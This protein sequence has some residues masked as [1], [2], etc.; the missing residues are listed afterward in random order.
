MIVSGHN[1]SCW[2]TNVP[3]HK[4][5]WAQLCLGTN[6][7][8]HK[9]VWAQTCLRTIISG[10][11]HVWAQS[12]LGT[13]VSGHNHVWAQSCL[14][15]NVCG[16]KRVWA[17]TCV[18]SVVWAQ[19]CWPN[20]VRA[21]TWWN[22]ENRQEKIPGCQVYKSLDARFVKC[23]GQLK[24]WTTVWSVA[25]YSGQ[26]TLEKSCNRAVVKGW[27]NCFRL[28]SL[29]EGKPKSP[30]WALGPGGSPLSFERVE[31]VWL[32]VSVLFQRFHWKWLKKH[33]GRHLRLAGHDGFCNKWLL[34]FVRVVGS[35]FGRRVTRKWLVWLGCSD[36]A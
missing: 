35:L 3:G 17:Q 24:R 19:S 32:G 9:R 4:R 28:E 1:N 6:V 7:S 34:N 36:F 31:C 10:H 2:G 23:V 30:C 14:G 18:G 20:H 22:Q 5:V 25:L 12:C 16:H 29:R 13:I 26:E 8:G 11:N 27:G 33:L 21:Q 15:T